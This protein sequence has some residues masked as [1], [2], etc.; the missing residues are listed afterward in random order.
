VVGGGIAGLTAAHR[1]VTLDSDL[2]VDLFERSDRSGG[3]IK[4]T[5]FAGHPVDEAADAFLTRVPWAV[6]LC[7]ELG[8]DDRLV[9]PSGL[10]ASIWHEDALHPI[11]TP[12]VLG[13][14]L[15]PEALAASG[16]V[17][18]A[19]VDSL[20][21]DRAGNGRPVDH[22]DSI[23]TLI[24]GRLGDEI[25]ERLVDPLI[26]GIYAAHPDDVSL[27][28]TVPQ[29]AAAAD[30]PSFTRA[31]AEAQDRAGTATEPVFATPRGGVGQLVDALEHRLGDRIHLNAVVESVSATSTGL[32]IEVDGRTQ[33]ADACVIATPAETASRLLASI[34][35]AATLAAVDAV[36][37]SIITLAFDR[38][39]VDGPLESSGFL[40]SRSSGLTMTACSVASAKW[41]HLGHDQ[42]VLR[43]S[44][45]RAGDDAIAAASDATLIDVIRRD[46]A[47]TLGIERPPT[48]MRISRWPHSFPRYRPGH[49]ERMAAV[50]SALAGS[51]IAIAGASTTGIGIPTCVKSGDAAARRTYE[52]LR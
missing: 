17:S 18:G 25:L 32:A 44:V 24:R 39:A 19:A 23:G 51:G 33:A 35:A 36:S 30:A 16:L 27:V 50:T 47:T 31:L 45:G 15:E 11:P 13:V 12:N 29:F 46:L 20:R 28:T 14:P 5:E 48:D 7:R 40:V 43:V 52:L 3:N 9:A 34:P 41:P 22:Q 6:D 4:T 42:V 1:L 2:D 38:E 26:G 49:L 8:L 21:H 37:V 10:P